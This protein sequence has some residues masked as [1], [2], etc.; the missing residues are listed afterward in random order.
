MLLLFGGL[1]NAPDDLVEHV[2]LGPPR[3]V[4]QTQPQKHC[5]LGP[6]KSLPRVGTPWEGERGTPASPFA[7][8]QAAPMRVPHA[9]LP[10]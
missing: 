3:A 2:G 8:C 6:G 5:R 4:A 1:A 10:V 7:F 9:S